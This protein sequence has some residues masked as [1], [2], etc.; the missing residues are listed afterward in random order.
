VLPDELREALGGPDTP[1]P[2]K[3]DGL[4]EERLLLGLALGAATEQIEVTWQ[5]ADEAGRGRTPSLALRETARLSHGTPE[6]AACQRDAI[7]HPSHPTLALEWLQR[8]GGM[9]SAAEERLLTTL[10]SIGQPDA[11]DDWY[12]DLIPGLNLLRATESFES[13]DRRFDGRIGTTELTQHPLSVSAVETLARCPLRFFFQR[14]LRV[15]EFDEEAAPFELT[16]REIGQH[17]HDLLERTY[18]MLHAEGLFDQP[19]AERMRRATEIL[20]TVWADTWH[21][22][23]QRLSRRAPALWAVQEARWKGAIARFVAA[24]LERIE[25]KAWGIPE[26]EQTIEGELS[27]GADRSLQLIGRVDRSFGDQTHRVIG[28]YKTGKVKGLTDATRMLKAQTLQVPLY[29]M[30]AGARARVEV[31][32]VG[33]RHDPDEVDE[34]ARIMTFGG[35]EKEVLDGFHETMRVLTDLIGDG[36]FPLKHDNIGCSYCPYEL[37]CRHRHPPTLEREEHAADR[38]DFSDLRH[39]NKSAKPT[40][41]AVRKGR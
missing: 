4:E 25:A 7:R 10:Q 11:L 41:Q 30:L 29:W 20:D 39:K 16:P 3:K 38:A 24:D 32:G 1:L 27:F 8:G 5:R 33:P 13:H 15:R 23:A 14:V 2:V 35:L 34:E 40:L 19:L 17:T 6:L 21:S 18:A 9:L 26:T 22:L 12:P 28:D 31:L 36:V 37:S